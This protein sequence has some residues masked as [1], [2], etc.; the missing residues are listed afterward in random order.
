M[1]PKNTKKTILILAIVFAVLLATFLIL[2]F[3][4]REEETPSPEEE[5]IVLWTISTLKIE[6][7]SY[8]YQGETITLTRENGTWNVNGESDFL[9][10]QFLVDSFDANCMVVRAA[11]VSYL[12]KVSDTCENKTLY[13]LQSPALTLRITV[14]GQDHIFHFGNRYAQSDGRY[15]QKEGDNAL[16]LIGEAYFTAFARTKT[17][18]IAHPFT[19]SFS[20]ATPQS[21]TWDDAST[22]DATALATLLTRLEGVTFDDLV[23]YHAD[24]T[25]YG[26][27]EGTR[28]ALTFTYQV[29]RD[30][31]DPITQT[32]TLYFGNTND[33]FVFYYHPDTPQL[34]YKMSETQFSGLTSVFA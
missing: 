30:G 26:L 31:S 7:L 23:D 14:D 27:E 9:L 3:T 6:R 2:Y 34:V 4:L 8:D 29:E 25:N 1:Q 15:C 16:Y 5:E 28:K 10:N 22:T 17:Q 19:P 11:N 20:G 32:Y 13:G 12:R 33:G 18:L 24:L 21:A